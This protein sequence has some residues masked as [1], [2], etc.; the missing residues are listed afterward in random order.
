MNATCDN[1]KQQQ[2]NI[3]PMNCTENVKAR[4]LERN[5]LCV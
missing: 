4:D 3:L 1:N 5:I 2:K